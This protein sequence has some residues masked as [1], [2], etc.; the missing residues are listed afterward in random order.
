MKLLQWIFQRVVHLLVY[1]PD[2]E[3]S[4]LASKPNA[5]LIKITRGER[6]LKRPERAKINSSQLNSRNL[7]PCLLLPEKNKVYII[8]M[9]IE[10][11]ITPP[12]VVSA[13]PKRLQLFFRDARSRYVLIISAENL[14]AVTLNTRKEKQNRVFSGRVA[15]LPHRP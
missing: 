15:E 9:Q 6:W 11:R 3:A 5:F 2:F 12:D 14:H 7:M 8:S 1:W 13:T 4:E 10:F